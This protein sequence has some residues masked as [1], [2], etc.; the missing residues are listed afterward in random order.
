[1][2]ASAIA[3]IAPAID[4]LLGRAS[5]DAELKAPARDQIGGAR[6]LDHV[7]RILIANIDDGCAYLDPAGPG[8]DCGEQGKGRSK[9]A[10]EWW[11]RK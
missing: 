9:L 5:A 2:S 3:E 11:T 6:I 10:G 8:S 1:M 4:D 7:E